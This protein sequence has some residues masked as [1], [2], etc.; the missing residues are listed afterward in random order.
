M[1][2]CRTLDWVNSGGVGSIGPSSLFVLFQKVWKMFNFGFIWL[3]FL[4]ERGTLLA[5]VF[6]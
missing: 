4:S 3:F 6:R 1:V 5:R 2:A